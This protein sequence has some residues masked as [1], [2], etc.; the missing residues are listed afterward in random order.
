MKS[1]LVDVLWTQQTRDCDPGAGSA[2][3][4]TP[5]VTEGEEV[6]RPQGGPEASAGGRL[7]DQG[8]PCWVL[9][10]EVAR[11]AWW[12]SV[13]VPSCRGGQKS[14]R[15]PAPGADPDFTLC[16]QLPGPSRGVILNSSQTSVLL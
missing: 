1:Y 3:G 11:E 8:Q 6:R 10:A 13:C 7:P 12:E 14:T 15:E 9:G 16:L 4:P 2:E 5:Q